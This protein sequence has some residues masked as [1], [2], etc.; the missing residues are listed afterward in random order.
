MG[1]ELVSIDSQEEFL[2]LNR[3]ISASGV[4]ITESFWTSG[5]DLA[6]EGRYVWENNGHRFTAADF[7]PA[8]EGQ[9]DDGSLGAG[10]PEDCVSLRK[11]FPGQPSPVIKDMWI[12]TDESCTDSE[13]LYI[14]REQL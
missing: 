9:P 14:C 8:G 2:Y 5:N 12:M 10:S 13:L 3:L 4:A 11:V 7:L 1:L 6:H